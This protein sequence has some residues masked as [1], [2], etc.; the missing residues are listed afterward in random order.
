MKISGARATGGVVVHY[1]GDMLAPQT[2]GDMRPAATSLNRRVR[3]A[4]TGRMAPERC[5]P[6]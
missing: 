5:G 2:L 3:R 1:Y 4:G 6:R